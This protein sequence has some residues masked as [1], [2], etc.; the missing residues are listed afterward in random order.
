MVYSSKFWSDEQAA[1]V[2]RSHLDSR[3]LA[4]P[5]PIRFLAGRRRKAWH[6]NVVA[7][8]LSSGFLEPLESTSIHLI[9]SGIAKLLSLFPTRDCYPETAAQFNRVFD[10]DVESVRDFLVLHY[11]RSAGRSEPMWEYCQHMSLPDAVTD[12]MAH[13]THTGRIVLATDELFKEA[14]WFAVMMGQGLEPSDYN[15]LVDTISA[16]E[17]RAH[18][19]RVEQQIATALRSMTRHEDHIRKQSRPS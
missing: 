4:E 6:K 1:Q 16:E 9:Q 7:I 12:K 18:L 13:F 15:P 17:N 2:L 3:A 11:H 8:G 19:A 14:S 5:R 10:A